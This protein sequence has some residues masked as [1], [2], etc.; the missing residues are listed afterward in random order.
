MTKRA[1]R[2]WP[3]AK[4][5]STVT[6]RP[7][8]ASARAAPAKRRAGAV[9]VEVVH[10]A[11]GEHEVEL[12]KILVQPGRVAHAELGAVAIA[13]ARALDVRLAYVNADVTDVAEVA[14]QV[15]GPTAEVEHPVSRKRPYVLANERCAAGLAAHEARPQLVDRRAREDATKA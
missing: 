13:P 9:V 3:S 7:P 5:G 12:T 10:D 8:G 14:H 4:A 6:T 1:A 11:E 2:G 15:T